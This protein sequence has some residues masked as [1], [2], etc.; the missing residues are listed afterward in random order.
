MSLE[1]DPRCGFAQS[2]DKMGDLMVPRR[3][4]LSTLQNS[5]SHNNSQQTVDPPYLGVTF[6]ELYTDWDRY[7]LIVPPGVVLLPGKVLHV[8]SCVCVVR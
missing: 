7:D 3:N 4:G 6:D 1:F 5:K 8:Y 2:E